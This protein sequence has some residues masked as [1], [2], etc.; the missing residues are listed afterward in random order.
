[1]AQRRNDDLKQIDS[2]AYRARLNIAKQYFDKLNAQIEAAAGDLISKNSKRHFDALTEILKGATT[3]ETKEYKVFVEEQ[4]N[5]INDAKVHLDALTKEIEAARNEYN[6]ADA[7]TKGP[8]SPDAQKAADHARDVAK[9]DLD[10]KLALQAEYNYKAKQ[11]D[12]NLLKHKEDNQKLLNQKIAELVSQ[13]IDT[14]QSLVDASYQQ[15][16]NHEQQLLDAIE[17]R[18]QADTDAI[19]TSMLNDRQK[20]KA[21]QKLNEETALKEKENAKEMNRIKR[22]QA[23]ADRAAS[24]L[25][26]VENTAI[27]IMAAEAIPVVGHALAIAD[28]AI[29]AA[30]IAAVLATPM[31]QY[32][33]GTPKGGHPG[34]PA[35]VGEDYRPELVIEPGKEPYIID[36]PTIR[37]FAPKTRVIPESD[38]IAG[39]MEAMAPKRFQ[40]V[41]IANDFSKLEDVTKQGFAKIETAITNKQE[42]HFTWI[43]G[44]LVKSVKKGNTYTTFAGT[45]NFI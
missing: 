31:P 26:I 39:V 12:D 40:G 41:N 17:A 38:M 45:N 8:L 25:K 1:L 36:R 16:L 11:A 18:K 22:E 3:R 15:Q 19:N 2:D 20:A 5:T 24:I 35:L 21:I 34:G 9:K 43:N 42:V 30:Q 13:G 37:D 29:G 44:E 27:A 7:A 6:S 28:A 23:I 33:F 32:R 4:L 14:V 10:D